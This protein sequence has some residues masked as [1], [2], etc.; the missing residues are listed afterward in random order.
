MK[1]V[2]SV[3]PTCALILALG[4]GSTRQATPT[5][6]SSEPTVGVSETRPA[7]EEPLGVEVAVEAAEIRGHAAV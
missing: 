7:P 5:T 2:R 6:A 1:H 3:A 4:C